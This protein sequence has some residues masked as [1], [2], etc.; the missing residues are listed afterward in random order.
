MSRSLPPELSADVHKQLLAGFDIFH[1]SRLSTKDD[2]AVAV[3]V[4]EG[5]LDS[6]S[7]GPI[8]LCSLQPEHPY[9]FEFIVSCK[10]IV[11]SRVERPLMLS[12]AISED[13]VKLVLQ[14]ILEKIPSNTD[15]FRDSL[16][17]HILSRLSHS[18]SRLPY[19]SGQPPDN[20]DDHRRDS[21][22]APALLDDLFKLSREGYIDGA[23][24]EGKSNKKNAQRG[25]TQRSKVMSVAHAEIN[26]RLFRA[27][28]RDAP[29]DRE[30]TEE[31][32]QSIVTAQKNTLKVRFPSSPS[33]HLRHA[34]TF[35][36]FFITLMRTPDTARLVRSAYFREN[37]LQGNL[38]ISDEQAT[39]SSVMGQ[40]SSIATTSD[41]IQADLYFESAANYGKWRILC[42][43]LCLSN[44]A[45]DGAQSDPVL[46]RLEYV[47]VISCGLT[48]RRCVF[49]QG[50][51]IGVF[52]R[53]EP[54]A[55]DEG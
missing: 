55:V 48:R 43:G 33:S 46:K 10:I 18:L 8:I 29:K 34:S 42:S 9:V 1:P 11:Y 20:F 44:L 25:K 24:A 54:N 45:R 51:F 3:N 37:V 13:S 14:F 38:S 52:F 49:S 17:H 31:L 28:G 40:S 47:H 39:P 22:A 23:E 4:L 32:V 21:E 16:G 2:I 19:P 30:S 36:Q 15:G 7:M 6:K 12:K 27:L 50:T 53:N 26:D 5:S 35:G 41:V